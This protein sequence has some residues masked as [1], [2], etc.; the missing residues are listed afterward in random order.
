M[1]HL[2]L[3]QA[4]PGS[5]PGEGA[6]VAKLD[7]TPGNMAAMDTTLTADQVPGDPDQKKTCTQCE[8]TFALTA[9]FWHR[10]RTAPSGFKSMCRPC[11]T[12]RD[13]GRT[14]KAAPRNAK[15]PSALTEARV[16][17]MH[18]LIDAHEVEFQRLVSSK[19]EQLNAPKRWYS[20]T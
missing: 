17:A 18:R 5:R 20:I 16:W 4:V 2:F 6:R 12:Q 13:R 8:Q 1:V 11:R 10:D 19:L 7:R 9:E 15:A 3:E 14:R